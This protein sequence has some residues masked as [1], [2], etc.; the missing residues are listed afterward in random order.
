MN[1][2]EGF[3]K[4]PSATSLLMAAIVLFGGWFSFRQLTVEAFPDPTDL[5][6]DV[7][8]ID[9]GQPTEEVERRVSIPLERALNGQ[10]NSGQKPVVHATKG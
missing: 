7:I 5:Q 4:R 9:A 3:I 1:I 10:W 2:S 6:V 8:T